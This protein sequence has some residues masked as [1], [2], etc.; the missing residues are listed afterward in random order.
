MKKL[1]Y[2]ALTNYEDSTNGVSKKVIVKLRDLKK[3]F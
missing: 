3:Q 1:L 2:L